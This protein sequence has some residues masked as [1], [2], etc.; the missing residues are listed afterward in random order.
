MTKLALLI[1]LFTVCA[2]VTQLS[3]TEFQTAEE[4]ETQL[5]QHL[6]DQVSKFDVDEAAEK[7]QDVIDE[8]HP[9][10]VSIDEALAN[11]A[12]TEK[13]ANHDQ[14]SPRHRK[15]LLKSLVFTEKEVAQFDAIETKPVPDDEIKKFVSQPEDHQETENFLATYSGVTNGVGWSVFGCGVNIWRLWEL[16]SCLKGKWNKLWADIRTL[17]QRI[18][19]FVRQKRSAFGRW[20][21]QAANKVRSAVSTVT[22]KWKAVLTRIK[23]KILKNPW[24]ANLAVVK[25][26]VDLVRKFGIIKLFTCLADKKSIHLVA[27]ALTNPV[28]FIKKIERFV[29]GKSQRMKIDTNAFKKPAVKETLGKIFQTVNRDLDDTAKFDGTAY[30]VVQFV[31]P[32]VGTLERLLRPIVKHTKKIAEG[33]FDK[34]VVPVLRWGLETA[35]SKIGSLE[36]DETMLLT[37]KGLWTDRLLAGTNYSKMTAD[38]TSFYSNLGQCKFSAAQSSLGKMTKESSRGYTTDVMGF[39]IQIGA[40]ALRMDLHSW[41][42]SA[43]AGLLGGGGL[44]GKT[45]GVLGKLLPGGAYIL[46][47]AVTALSEPLVNLMN[48]VVDALAGL[49]P[50]V[51][52]AIFT[53]VVSGTLRL[54][55][56]YVC[57]PLIKKLGGLLMNKLA[58]L[59]VDF[60]H[61]KLQGWLGG[62]KGQQKLYTALGPL[63]S[64]F[65]KVARKVLEGLTPE[66]VKQFVQ[67]AKRFDQTMVWTA[68]KAFAHAKSKKCA[69]RAGFTKGLDKFYKDMDKQVFTNQLPMAVLERS[70]GKVCSHGTASVP[71]AQCLAAGKVA[72]DGAKQGRTNLIVGHW[73]WFASGCNIYKSD[74][75]V[76]WNTCKNG[77]ASIHTN[78]V[79]YTHPRPEPV[80]SSEKCVQKV[81]KSECLAAGTKA[82]H[83]AKM[84]RRHLVVGS[85]SFFPTGCVVYTHASHG[86]NAIHWNTYKNGPTKTA[87]GKAI[88][89]E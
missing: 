73:C 56:N 50:E 26:L 37:V 30:C 28:G 74:N 34:V 32:F 63:A 60:I 31:R 20:A 89:Y 53:F 6:A 13:F 35:V 85:W 43:E 65:D 78:L 75:A 76:H 58:D 47:K 88:C 81:P 25:Q 4:Y 83:G 12:L 67:E 15:K 42:D 17:H 52:A 1:C 77:P 55:W 19:N 9:T 59:G 2:A 48:R 5:N 27:A 33:A 70:N 68:R 57:A 24:F 38:A 80:L 8:H 86:D 29:K 39:A 46:D 11:I 72:I 7:M 40:K 82:L 71:K 84:G 87:W 18:H 10:S 62:A 69:P 44:K 79:C 3:Y 51:G 14:L 36:G 45:N 64:I 49:I 16:G 61:D 21:R 22:R 54:F 41:V 23:D 66:S